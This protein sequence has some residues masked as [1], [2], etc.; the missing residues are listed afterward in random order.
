MLTFILVFLCGSLFAQ[1]ELSEHIVLE[2][3]NFTPDTIKY[4]YDSTGKLLVKWELKASERD[5]M[6]PLNFG[7]KVR[8][9]LA[10]WNEFDTMNTK[11]V[12][13]QYAFYDSIQTLRHIDYH[14]N[15]ELAYVLNFR[16][17]R[18]HGQ[19]LMQDSL[20]RTLVSGQFFQNAKVGY[21]RYY[22]DTGELIS[23]GNYLPKVLIFRGKEFNILVYGLNNELIEEY[24]PS[25]DRHEYYFPKTENDDGTS[26]SHVSFPKCIYYKTGLWHYYNDGEEIIVDETQD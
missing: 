1:Q 17:G 5:S 16:N 11:Q 20:G 2:P 12:C 21:W 10:V 7:K 25:S 13:V 4:K 24:G 19:F 3:L 18:L 15:G 23:E 6:L 9:A 14:S 8:Y 22:N 26:S